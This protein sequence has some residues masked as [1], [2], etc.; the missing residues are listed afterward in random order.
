[1]QTMNAKCSAARKDGHPCQAWAVAGTSPPRCAAHGGGTARVGAPIGNENAR[2]H[3]FYCRPSRPIETIDDAMEHLA[4]SLIQLAEYIREHMHELTVDEMA[5]LS[6]VRGQNLSR[7]VRMIKD[8]AILTGD[9]SEIDAHV[10]RAL[11]FAS[12]RLGVPL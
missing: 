12:E 6:S 8:R 3:G 4:E 1:M 2:K 10:E 5:R 9:T 11:E 7:Y